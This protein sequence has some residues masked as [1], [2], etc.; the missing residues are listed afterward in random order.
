MVYKIERP[1]P[2]ILV[3]QALDPQPTRDT[4]ERERRRDVAENGRGRA[5]PDNGGEHVTLA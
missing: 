2:A 5:K 1:T 3:Q 4:D